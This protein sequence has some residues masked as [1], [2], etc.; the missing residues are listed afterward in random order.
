MHGRNGCF[1][2]RIRADQ[3]PFKAGQFVRLQLPVDGELVAKSYS[4]VNAPDEPDIEV[5]LQQTTG[6]S[7][8]QQT[9][10]PSDGDSIEISQPANGFFV[11]DEI[12]ATGICGCLQRVPVWGPIFRS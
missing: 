8:L 7:V 1:L 9:G 6:W 4:L 10:R 12:P 3:M 2:K 5:F 11:L